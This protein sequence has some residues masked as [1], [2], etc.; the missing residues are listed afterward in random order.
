MS[1][2]HA[3]TLLG[4]MRLAI[5]IRPRFGVFSIVDLSLIE[6]TWPKR[7]LS[8]VLEWAF[9]H[10]EELME[11]WNLA[12]SQKPLRQIAPLV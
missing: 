4:P 11:D 12:M 5:S 1:A 2:T 6:G 7:V 8:L 10:R 9:E 3:P